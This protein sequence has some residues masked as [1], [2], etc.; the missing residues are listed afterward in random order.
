LNDQEW[1]KSSL[2]NIREYIAFFNNTIRLK[3]ICK[4]SI[5]SVWM[6]QSCNALSILFPVP[7]QASIS[8]ES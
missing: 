4:L 7:D 3:L 8:D 1:I 2:D 6:P 5:T